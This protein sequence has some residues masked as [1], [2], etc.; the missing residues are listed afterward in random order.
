MSVY[1]KRKGRG[2]WYCKFPTR[3]DPLT[4]T[5]IYKIKRIGPRQLAIRFD[6]KKKEE[7]AEKV[8]YGRECEP[9][10]E[11]MITY[12]LGLEEVRAKR[13]YTKDIQHCG[14]L[15]KEFGPLV[16]S[17]I[18]QHM[19]RE[20]R[21]RMRA[22]KSSW[23]KTF[24]DSTINKILQVGRRVYNIASERGLVSHP[25]PFRGLLLKENNARDRVLSPEE[26]KRLLEASPPH[27]ACIIETAY[28]SGMR[29]GEIL[30]L[31]WDRV[32]MKE[33]YIQLE[34]EDTKTTEP[35]KIYFF[36]RVREI[37]WEL[38][39][40]RSLSHRFIFMYQSRPIKSIKT[41][42]KSAC[43]KAGIENLRF[44]DLRHTCVTNLRKAGVERSVI[45]KLTGHKTLAMFSRYNT[46][47]SEDARLA[48]E[49]LC[50][51]LESDECSLFAPGREK[52]EK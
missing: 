31:T 10:F 50:R 29:V 16:A 26:L 1:E 52:T 48:M 13:S 43:E 20:F 5:I 22:T 45:M 36:P 49:R 27:L 14:V 44:H 47:D 37:L 40:V 18:K 17:N 34:A 4:G 12:Y 3:R 11:E 9:T 39:R 7:W 46:V 35:R 15:K 21:N 41:A 28:Y 2:V 42:F 25:N 38:R 19:V 33:G 23:G 30:G 32:N 6:R 8:F 51:F 24:A